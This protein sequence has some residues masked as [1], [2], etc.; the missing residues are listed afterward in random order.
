M[1]FTT[2]DID[3]YSDK[4]KFCQDCIYLKRRKQ[5]LLGL[6]FSEK[7]I[8]MAIYFT[9]SAKLGQNSALSALPIYLAVGH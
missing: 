5:W 9:F 4:S 7:T 1:L 3:A 6:I 2:M 8:C